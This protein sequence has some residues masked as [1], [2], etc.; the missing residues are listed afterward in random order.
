MFGPFFAPFAIFDKFKFV[1]S[2][3][4]IFFGKIIL[5]TTFT[6]EQGNEDSRCFFR[7][8]HGDIITLR[9]GKIQSIQKFL[10]KDGFG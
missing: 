2:V 7:F 1:G 5:G 4:F 10:I 8:S 3:G 6:A 9:G